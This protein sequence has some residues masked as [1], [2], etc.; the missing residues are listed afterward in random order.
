M[1]TNSSEKNRE[2]QRKWYEKNRLLQMERNKSGR[3][4]KKDYI[5]NYKEERGCSRCGE[6]HHACLQFHHR[7]PE[8][9]EDAVANLMTRNLSLDKIIKEMEKCDVICA[10]CHIKLHYDERINGLTNGL[11]G[12]SSKLACEGSTPSEAT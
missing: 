7:N 3:D 6:K 8:E 10:N 1:T 12:E 5:K 2:Y 4:K 9:K 11:G